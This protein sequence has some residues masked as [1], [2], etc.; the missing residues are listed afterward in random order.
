MIT[1]NEH[2][3]E[4]FYAMVE[5]RLKRVRCMSLA[6][7]REESRQLLMEACYANSGT[8]RVYEMV[9]AALEDV[10]RGEGSE[11]ELRP[12]WEEAIPEWLR[13]GKLGEAWSELRNNGVLR[14]DYHCSGDTYCHDYKYHTED[15]IQLS[16]QFIDRE[17]CSRDIVKKDNDDPKNVSQKFRC[18][19]SNQ[20]G[21][22][23]NENSTGK[24]EQKD[25]EN[26]HYI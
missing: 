24:Q 10:E 11:E 26:T 12:S 5:A 7:A 18:E 6:E 20:C 22:R 3:E 2:I 19:L 23:S 9:A 25:R 1:L 15:R 21:R 17:Q 13:M 4:V 14:E 8:R 16:D